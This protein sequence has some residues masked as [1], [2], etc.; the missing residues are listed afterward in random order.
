M[1][2]LPVKWGYTRERDPDLL[3]YPDDDFDFRA[4]GGGQPP[5]E[6][7]GQPP[8]PTRILKEGK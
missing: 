5:P 2:P 4:T 8:S 1:I 3:I 7:G 6:G